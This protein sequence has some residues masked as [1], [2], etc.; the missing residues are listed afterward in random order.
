MIKVAL[1]GGIGSGKSAAGDFFEDLGAVVVDADQLAR[2][3][4]ERG[5]DGF[6]ELVA[7]FGDEILTNGILDRSKLGQIVFADPEAR[8]TLEGIIHPRVAQ[9]FEEII[10]ESPEDAVIIYQIPILVETKGQDRFDYVITVEASL[11]NRITRLKNRGL[12]GY[13]IEARLKAQASDEQRAEIADLI[14]KND[15]DLDSLLRQVENI[16]EDVLLPRARANVS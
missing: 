13:E 5:T 16:Y 6:D 2:D 8:K 10:E 4:I 9:A 11:E 3:V 14:F 12:K 15:G 1:T 7:T